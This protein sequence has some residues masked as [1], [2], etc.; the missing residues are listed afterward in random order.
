VSGNFPG[1]DFCQYDEREKLRTRKKQFAGNSFKEF[2]AEFVRKAI[3]ALIAFTPSLA[4]LDRSGTALLLMGGILF[5]TCMESLR[6]LGFSP[7]LFSAVAS[8]A[9]RKRERES[10]ALGPVTLGLGAL[11]TLILFPPQPA[12][13]AIY[14]LA[15]GDST[16]G[17]YGRFLGRIRPAFLQGKS[18]EGSLVCFSVSF[19]AGFLVFGEWQTALAVSLAATIVDALPLGDLDNILIPLAAGLAALLFH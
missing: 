8:A 16:S 4:A 5:Y 12:A 3:H 6:F 18:L 14:V 9:M 17:L 1:H 2:K 19:L 11:L 10:F 7:P 15:F 13:A